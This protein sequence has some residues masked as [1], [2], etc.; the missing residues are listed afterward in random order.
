MLFA[1]SNIAV[2]AR[3]AIWCLNAVFPAMIME[4][5]IEATSSGR[6]ALGSDFHRGNHAA[7]A[8]DHHLPSI[9][10]NSFDPLSDSAARIAPPNTTTGGW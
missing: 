10:E 3:F 5:Y 1:A 9:K 2:S 7:G 4:Q 8:Q 6:L